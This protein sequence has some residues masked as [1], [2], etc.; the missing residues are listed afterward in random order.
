[1]G[2]TASLLMRGKAG[3][4]PPLWVPFSVWAIPLVACAASLDTI[5]G[6]PLARGL[7]M[8]RLAAASAAARR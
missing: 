7:R 3:A 1:L 6:G 8:I 2:I 5:F 4:L